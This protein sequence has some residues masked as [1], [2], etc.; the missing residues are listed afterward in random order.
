MWI[1]MIGEWLLFEGLS[2]FYPHS[3]FVQALAN[4]LQL[5]KLVLPVH[6]IFQRLLSL[7]SSWLK[8]I[9]NS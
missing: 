3:Q 7:S 5:C 1:Q 8:G 4:T 6:L 2:D 9:I